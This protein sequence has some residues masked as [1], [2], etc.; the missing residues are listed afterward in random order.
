MQQCLIHNDSLRLSRA[1]YGI[2]I[3]IAC[4][5]QN[6]WLVLM[7]SLL[8]I[9]G[10]F[11]IKFNI[12]YQLLLLFFKKDKSKLIQ[13]ELE[14]LNFVSGMTGILLFIGFLFLYFGKFVDFVWM[15]ILIIALLIFLACFVGFC[16]A[17]LIY[18]FFKKLFKWK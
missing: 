4:L 14:E 13:R 8:L 6:Q 5:I 7:V 1:T 12:P 2:V 17:T 11:S 10:V 18:V 16:I 15:Y 9:L 3:L